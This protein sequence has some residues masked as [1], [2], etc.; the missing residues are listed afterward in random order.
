MLALVAWAALTAA[1]PEPESPR[2]AV[3]AQPIG[4]LV[5]VPALFRYGTSIGWLSAGVTVPFGSFELSLDAALVLYY[6]RTR[7]PVTGFGFSA[8][9]G[10]QFSF[11]D[12][13][14]TGF[15][16]RPK[17]VI[18]VAPDVP[19][20]SS[21]RTMWSHQVGLDAGYQFSTPRLYLALHAGIS[22]GYGFNQDEDLFG[23][24]QPEGRTLLPLR[25]KF[26]L[27]LN[28]HLL[29]IGVKL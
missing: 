21:P 27:G 25:D 16:V 12:A 2:V 1:S 7:F 8:S 26:V 20:S 10:P 18:D 13:P 22:A 3:W 9:V 24:P 19:T 28:L 11:G 4:A 17:Y 23:G 14:L 6:Q 15:F 5:L 29:K